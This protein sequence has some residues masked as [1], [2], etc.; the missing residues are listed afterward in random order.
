[1]STK[2][3]RQSANQ[4]R[5]SHFHVNGSATKFATAGIHRSRTQLACANRFPSEFDAATRRVAGDVRVVRCLDI[6]LSQHVAAFPTALAAES[7]GGDKSS[8]V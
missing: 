3:E 6:P 5:L 7:R 8:P 1:M 2:V 4:H